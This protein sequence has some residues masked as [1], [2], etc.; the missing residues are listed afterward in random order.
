MGVLSK[1]LGTT[2]FQ[3]VVFVD[4]GTPKIQHKRLQIRLRAGVWTW[5]QTLA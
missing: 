5:G 1:S 4:I 2:R 3:R